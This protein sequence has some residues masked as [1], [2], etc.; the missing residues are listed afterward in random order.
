MADTMQSVLCHEHPGL[1]KDALLNAKQRLLIISPWIRHQ[2][3]NFEFIVGLRNAL[4]RGVRV[5]IGYGIDAGDEQ[6]NN[7]ANNKIAITTQAKSDLEDLARKHK[8]FCFVYVGNTHRK[9]LVCDDSFAVTT[10]F[11]WLSFRGDKGK[12][13]D[14]RGW[15]V[16]KK[17][18]IDMQ[19]E[20]DLR[21]LEVGYDGAPSDWQSSQPS[22]SGKRK[23]S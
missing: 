20:D 21:L 15:L 6:K 22:Q 10:S 12:P 11:N 4:K 16:R 23:S 18:Y 19:F 7:G 14:E 2:V 8:N 1:L 5:Y 3:V 9:S 17:Q 13:R